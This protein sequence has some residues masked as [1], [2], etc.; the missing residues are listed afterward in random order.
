MAA[1]VEIQVIVNPTDS[2]AKL[3]AVQ[4]EVTGIG[5]ASTG[6]AAKVGQ[7][8][9]QM[10][11]HIATGLDSVRLLSQEFG[12]RMPRAIEQMLSRMPAVTSALGNI[13]GAMAGVAGIEIFA[14]VITGA[15]E[16]YDKFFS[17]NTI[18]DKYVEN[19]EK[20]RQAD[21]P[22]SRSIETT[23]QRL[24]DQTHGA[25]LLQ[26]QAR[27]QQ[28]Q[29]IQTAAGGTG[30]SGLARAVLLGPLAMPYNLVS[31]GI[32]LHQATTTQGQ[33]TDADVARNALS[34][35]RI[36]DTHELAIAQIDFNHAQDATLTGAQK[37]DAELAKKVA[38]NAETRAY[39]NAQ[40]K[41]FGNEISPTAG[42]A[43][44]S[45]KDLAATGEAAAQKTK[46]GQ[47][48]ALA[49]MKADD[50]RVQAGMQGEDLYFRKM[51]DDVR[52]TTR[53]LENQGKAAEI[54]SRV[55]EINEK[56]YADLSERAVKAQ[57]ELGASIRRS[58]ASGLTGAARIYADQDIQVNENNTKLANDPEAQHSANVAA[59]G[60]ANQ[61]IEDLQRQFAER[62]E[63]IEAGRV[64]ATMNGY[65]RIA[66]EAAKTAVQ[67]EDD[68]AKSWG[69]ASV[70]QNS[71][72]FLAAKQAEQNALTA[73]Q[74]GADA[75]RTELSQANQ[76]EDLR[77]DQQ[78]AEAEKRT[79][80]G[81]A[82]GWVAAE[83]NA[84][85]AINDAEQQRLAKLTE[86]ANKEGLT[87][88]EVARRRTDIEAEAAA[89]IEQQQQAMAGKL[90]GLFESAFKD[91]I[92]TIKS[93]MEKLMFD[94]LAQWIMHFQ[95]VK[96]L[97]GSSATGA[98]GGGAGGAG[99][100]GGG[101]GHMA[102]GMAGG[103]IAHFIG[104]GGMPSIPGVSG[105]GGT[106][107]SAAGPGAAGSGGGYRAPYSGGVGATGSSGM[108]TGAGSA[109]AVG[110]D[111]SSGSRIARF[112]GFGGT[113]SVPGVSGPGA[114][115]SGGTGGVSDGSGSG[116]SVSAPRSAMAGGPVGSSGMV[117]GAGSAASVGSDLSSARSLAAG[118]GGVAATP[119]AA[120]SPA[121][122]AGAAGIPANP[123]DV[124]EGPGWGLGGDDTSAGMPTPSDSTLPN[125][126]NGLPGNSGGGGLNMGGVNA[127]AGA[128]APGGA[129]S[130]G[131]GYAGAAGAAYM[132]EQTTVSTF[133]KGTPG[134]TMSGMLGDAA[135]GATIGSVIPG[136]G[137]AIGAGIG[138]LVGLGAGIAGGV[139]GMAGNI[140]ARNYYE[141]TLFPAIE[142]DR[143][144]QGG[145]P[146]SSISDVNRQA[147]QGFAYMAGHWGEN[148]ADWVKSNYLDKEVQLALSQIS[149][150]ASGGQ[151]YTERQAMQFDT[152]GY[153]GDFG[154]MGTGGA[155]GFVHT[156][157]GETV[158]NQSATAIHAP[159]LNAMNDGA[160]PGDVASMYLKSARAGSSS[161]ASA[162]G[163]DTHYHIH[164]LDTKTMTGWLNNGGA[165]MISKSQ[166]NMAGQYAGDGVIG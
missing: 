81:G 74:L 34:R 137:T 109:S 19:M 135:A 32:E 27:D 55:R 38:L 164:T 69:G 104:G 113:P 33:S 101:V 143:L 114:T 10:N 60:E 120:M 161:P 79:K 26:S 59:A 155:H 29:A 50:A 90:S 22:N 110:G 5:T 115:G 30:M 2:A 76:A 43:E 61:K 35:K 68:F 87:W 118:F 149:Q 157:L 151:E 98:M 85:T 105:S 58:G 121:A 72:Q 123:Y 133:D 48:S 131:L 107:S 11:G 75:K 116:I 49:I 21:L 17:L 147:T 126:K 66:A 6:A 82:L 78:A 96:E 44:E 23:N 24:Q 46:L 159:V 99:G 51:Q 88:E 12:M 70:D 25:A 64:D 56:Y 150:H 165:R 4:A 141:K 146:M 18:I 119:A 153:I 13:V 134:G 162:P 80:E 40:D 86:D 92:G 139:M 156:L 67:I 102:A 52:E 94:L 154:D 1:A 71:A 148:A 15:I 128:T 142:A 39:Q 132:A 73:V 42:V 97:F 117:T 16:A 129:L 9:G 145:D 14:R 93:T 7:G 95:M 112:F 84:I 53:E 47:D 36:D 158:M 8:M 77:Y 28:Q 108:V 152:G 62:M 3:G 127:A 111:I 130:T 106:G 83:K 31:G 91:P 54:P 63:S 37:I 124:T 100:A 45:L 138:A 65:D 89:Q 144:G 140:P 166:N 57:N 160:D 103:A 136:I 122:A 125:I 20:A 41:S 163:G